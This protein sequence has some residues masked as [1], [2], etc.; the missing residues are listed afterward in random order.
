LV[1]AFDALSFGDFST[2]FDQ[3]NSSWALPSV[4][5]PDVTN[6]AIIPCKKGTEGVGKIQGKN[7]LAVIVASLMV[8][9]SRFD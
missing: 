6:R 8:F 3:D 9:Y 2:F 7:Y 1:S 5:R 4:I